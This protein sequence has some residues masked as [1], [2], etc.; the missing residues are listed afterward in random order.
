MKRKTKHSLQEMIKLQ[1]MYEQYGDN[2][3]YD[4]NGNFH[5]V[6]EVPE[7]LVEFLG[8]MQ[9]AEKQ[10]ENFISNNKNKK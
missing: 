4:K 9:I 5:I 7:E 8:K 10:F 2:I 6:G 1:N 3:V